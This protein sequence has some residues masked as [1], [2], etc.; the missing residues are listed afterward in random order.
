MLARNASVNF[1]MF[2]GGTNFGFTAGM[3]RLFYKC[4]NS[5][6][7]TNSLLYSGAN[8]GGPGAFNADVTSYDYDGMTV[9]ELHEQIIFDTF[10]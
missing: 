2:I 3:L 1:Y 8:D 10:N 4:F 9:E 6:F 7:C 5:S